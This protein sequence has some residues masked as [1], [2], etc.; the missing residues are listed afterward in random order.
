MCDCGPL[1]LVKEHL[2]Y[3]INDL[4]QLNCIHIFSH[5]S[6][7]RDLLDPD[8]DWDLSNSLSP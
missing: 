2:C 3:A 8:P 1:L 6:N 5:V 4:P 7:Y